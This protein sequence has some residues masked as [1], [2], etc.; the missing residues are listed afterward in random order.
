MKILF[1]IAAL[2]LVSPMAFANYLGPGPAPKVT[3][4]TAIEAATSKL[5]DAGGPPDSYVDRM[6]LIGSGKDRV[7]VIWFASPSHGYTILRVDMKK[8]VRKASQKEVD[9]GRRQATE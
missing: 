1:Q 6:T 4:N 7:W 5:K 3:C 9:T 8:A 2:L